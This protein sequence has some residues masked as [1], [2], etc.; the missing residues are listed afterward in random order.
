MVDSLNDRLIRTALI[1]LDKNPVD[2]LS[3]RQ[4]AQDNGVSHQAPYVHF[5]SKR[6][7]LAAVAGTGLQQAVDEAISI[8]TKAGDEPRMRLHAVADAY[9]SFIR[10]RPHVHD[11]AYGPMVAKADH[12]LLQQ[13][14]IG[15]WNLVHDAVARCQPPATS[16]ADILR[17]CVAAWGAVY[18]IARL[19]ALHQIP[20]SVPGDHGALLHEALDALYVGWNAAPTSAV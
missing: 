3:I 14:A 7:F 13:A 18:G 1:L 10:T 8:L 4:V 17:R 5:G 19:S 11:L 12:P 16:E 6:R 15:Y 20:T 2:R 9:I